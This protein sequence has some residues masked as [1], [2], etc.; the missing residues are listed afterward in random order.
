M[1]KSLHDEIKQTEMQMLKLKKRI[2]IA[3]Q[4]VIARQ[5]DQNKR[6]L[7]D[8]VNQIKQAANPKL[9]GL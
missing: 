1:K 8:V 6:E 9:T 3:E 7:K 2:L 4:L 5:F